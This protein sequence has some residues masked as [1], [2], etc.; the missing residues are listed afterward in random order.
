[1]SEQTE[2][3]RKTSAETTRRFD[4]LESQMLQAMNHTNTAMESI[5]S[6]DAKVEQ[7]TELMIRVTTIL[8]AQGAYGNVSRSDENFAR[9]PT[10]SNENLLTR[11]PPTPTSQ[12]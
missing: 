4:K 10:N 2:D 9:L 1:M 5:A 7:L 3:I 12:P 8:D 11:P 6:L